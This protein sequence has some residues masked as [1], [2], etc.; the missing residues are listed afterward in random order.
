MWDKTRREDSDRV[1]RHWLVL[2]VATLWTLAYGSRVEDANDRGIA[3]GR[4]RA[5]PK[6]LAQTHRSAPRRIVSVL[7]LGMSWLRRLLIRGRLWRR[8]WLLPEPWPEPPPDM[9]LIYHEYT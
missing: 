7:R 4:L 1:S 9:K 2:S 3:P 6:A 8:V 5:P